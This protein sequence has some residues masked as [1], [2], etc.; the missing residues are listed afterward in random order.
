MEKKKKCVGG[1]LGFMVA[2]PGRGWGGSRGQEGEIQVEF[3]TP[4][5][6]IRQLS[7]DKGWTVSKPGR[8]VECSHRG[9]IR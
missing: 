7:V 9:Q 3:D 8:S 6:T 4:V 5:R 2:N 1:G